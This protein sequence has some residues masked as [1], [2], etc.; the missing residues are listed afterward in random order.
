MIDSSII[1]EKT[2]LDLDERAMIDD[3]YSPANSQAN[4]KATCVYKLKV[5]SQ[6]AEKLKTK[7]T[8]SLQKQ[9]LMAYRANRANR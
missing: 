9:T 8:L 7:V 4:D 5:V 2:Y 6:V 1:G 3:Y